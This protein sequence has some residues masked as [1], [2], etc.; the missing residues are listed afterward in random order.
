MLSD[1]SFIKMRNRFV[2]KTDPRGTPDNTGT[3]SEA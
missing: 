1:K 2:P 3:G